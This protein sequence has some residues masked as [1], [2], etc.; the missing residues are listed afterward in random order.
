MICDRFSIFIVVFLLFISVF[1]F[2]IVLLFISFFLFI[3]IIIMVSWFWSIKIHFIYT[4]IKAR[5]IFYWTFLLLNF[6]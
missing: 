5:L 1:L 4:I 6:D 3:T 2:I